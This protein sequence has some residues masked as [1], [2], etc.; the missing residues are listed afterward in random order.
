MRDDSPPAL[1]IRSI[2]KRFPGVVALNEVSF[3]VRAGEVHGL[4]GENGAGKS[5]L[6]KIIAGS[7]QRDSG[8]I[9]LNG[10]PLTAITPAKM[11]ELG[12]SVIY[13]ELSLIR[14]MTVASN[15]FLGREQVL[16]APVLRSLGVRD[17]TGMIEFC[18][19]LFSE[20]QID[21]DPNEVVDALSVSERQLVEIARAVAFNAQVILMDEPTTSI[22]PREKSQL[23]QLIGRLKARGIAIVYVSHILEDCLVICD[24]ITVLRD[25]LHVATLAAA[26]STIDHLIRLITGRTFSDRYPRIKSYPGRRILEVKALSCSGRIADISFDLHEGEILGFA[27]LVGAGRTELMESLFGLHPADSGEVLL[28]GKRLK[29][30]NPRDAIASGFSLLTEDRKNLGILPNLNVRDNIAITALNFSLAAAAEGLVWLGQVMNFRRLEMLAQRFIREVNLKT[31]STQ[32]MIVE[33]SGGNQQKSL[34]ARSLS[35]GARI[36][37]L[38]EPTKGVDAGAKIE[39]YRMLQELVDRKLGLLVVSS[40]LPEILAVSHRIIVMK[41]GRV[42]ATL[43]GDRTN[44]EG[45][46]R[47]ATV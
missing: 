31:R 21:I 28:D 27:G 38:D 42:A 2:G 17:E 16:D 12:I 10:S 40:E 36:V 9:L 46:M 23:F 18:R 45:I 3:D 29:I 24:R 13:Q 44:A 35:S 6:I 14:K 22:G 32:S 33:L 4:L 7:Q 11:R 37:I 43:P 47:F 1:G 25:G 26:D 15:I 5:T 39:I 34:L 41:G 30:R 8:D 20:L 19:N